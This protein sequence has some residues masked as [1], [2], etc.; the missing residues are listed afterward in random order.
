MLLEQVDIELLHAKERGSPGHGHHLPGESKGGFTSVGTWVNSNN[1]NLLRENRSADLNRNRHQN[2]PLPFLPRLVPA[3]CHFP[4][5]L[6]CSR[7]SHT[8]RVFSCHS[9]PTSV[10]DDGYQTSGHNYVMLSI[11]RPKLAK[12]RCGHPPFIPNTG[13][14]SPIKTAVVLTTGPRHRFLSLRF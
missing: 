7:S 5:A 1:T 8:S 12:R 6:P 13:T 10:Q 11:M 3:A 14:A 9:G 2:Q 4:L